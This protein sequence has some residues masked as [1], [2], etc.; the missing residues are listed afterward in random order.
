MTHLKYLRR[1]AESRVALA[2]AMGRSYPTWHPW[3]YVWMFFWW[4]ACRWEDKLEWLC[5]MESK[6]ESL[7]ATFNPQSTES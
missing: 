3:R 2:E 6:A 1:A 7:A 4:R 5:D